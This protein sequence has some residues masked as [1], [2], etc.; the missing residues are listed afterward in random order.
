VKN[1]R[2]RAEELTRA[3]GARSPFLWLG[4]LAAESEGT[5][6]Q[7]V[8]SPADGRLVGRVATG[9][10]RDAERAVRS[11]R[12]ALRSAPPEAATS[13][14]AQ[15]ALRLA[16]SIEAE[17]DD[18]AILIALETGMPIREALVHEVDVAVRALRQVA[19][20]ALTPS[21][22][23]LAL[24]PGLGA[25]L[26][27]DG[28]KVVAVV[29]SWTSPLA[30][31][32]AGLAACLGAGAAAILKPHELAPFTALR[33]GELATRAGVP[34]GL[35]AVLPGHG[36]TVGE[37]LALHPDVDALW[38][39]GGVET[40]RRLLVASAKSNLK[41]IW[42][43]LPGKNAAIV[44]DDTPL[45]RTLPALWRA[46]LTG[47]GTSRAHP[48]RVLVHA[49]LHDDVAEALTQRA[50]EINAGDPL[51]EHAEL[52]P[53]PSEE[54]VSRFVAYAE[55]GRRE[56]ARLVA[57]GTRDQAGERAAGHFVRP[58]VLLDVR[59]DM[60]IAR[61]AVHGPLLTIERFR[62]EDE[63]IEQANATPFGLAASV[64]TEE[65]G[66]ARR[67]AAAL[68]VGT[69]WINGADVVDPALPRAGRSLSG[70]GGDLGPTAVDQLTAPKAVYWVG[71]G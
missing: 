23:A 48:S 60:R 61:E 33:L 47:R 64:F 65:L 49:S 62:K 9:S 20:H 1:A 52:G 34:A 2:V 21:G 54:H 57:G 39:Q 42:P 70:H 37:A 28:R 12:D 7:T 30:G 29:T 4:G 27:R 18:F 22:A 17:A 69:V 53:L 25:E 40:A 32:A 58:T 66:R 41:P 44:F 14:R 38:F 46:A 45:G 8:L 24:R 31:P 71:R 55:L 67:V 19:A 35:V 10:E 59:R 26:R 50:R 5:G 16:D 13:E 11:A 63:A 3:L 56:G 43:Q 36:A 68:D 51:D 6:T 15:L